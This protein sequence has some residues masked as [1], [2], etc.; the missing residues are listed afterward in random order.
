[1]ATKMRPRAAAKSRPQ[2]ILNAIVRDSL[3]GAPPRRCLVP[4][5]PP[6]PHLHVPE[7]PY[8]RT[9]EQVRS[10]PVRQTA[11]QAETNT[12]EYAQNRRS[13]DNRSQTG[14]GRPLATPLLE[15]RQSREGCED[16]CLRNLTSDGVGWPGMR[17]A[18][19]VDAKLALPTSGPVACRVDRMTLSS[20]STADYFQATSQK[21]LPARIFVTA[22]PSAL[23]HASPRGTDRSI[24]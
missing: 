20:R 23:A 15:E 14:Q 1:M 12:I 4:M 13:E 18:L 19:R 11:Q 5:S 17:R 8:R 6:S 9:P 2:V 21:D 24:A 16:H 3:R 10:P 22:D 7:R